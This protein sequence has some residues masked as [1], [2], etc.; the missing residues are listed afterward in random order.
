M[1]RMPLNKLSRSIKQ[2]ELG[3]NKDGINS[4]IQVQHASD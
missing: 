4:T 3:F 2:K 1:T